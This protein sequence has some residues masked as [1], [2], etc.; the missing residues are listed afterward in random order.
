MLQSPEFW[1]INSLPCIWRCVLVWWWWFLEPGL[2]CLWVS[3]QRGCRGPTPAL[4]FSAAQ[5]LLCPRALPCSLLLEMLPAIH[6]MCFVLAPVQKPNPK[7]FRFPE[8]TKCSCSR[9]C[10]MIPENSFPWAA[11][12][13]AAPLGAFCS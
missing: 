12:Q 1:A 4:P 2:C 3:S 9:R 11:C 10:S 8:P 7:K 5:D 6:T 13:L